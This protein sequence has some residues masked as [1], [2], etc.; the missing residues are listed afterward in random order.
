MQINMV[1]SKI[2][3]AH[4]DGLQS[5]LLKRGVKVGTYA[6]ETLRFVTHNGVTREEIEQ[7]IG[8]MQEYAALA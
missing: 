6:D 3:W 1:F 2:D 5:W 8:L 4:L 7:V